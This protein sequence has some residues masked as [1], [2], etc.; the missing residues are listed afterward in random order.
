[1]HGTE[2]PFQYGR[3]DEHAHIP[4]SIA[5]YNAQ[6]EAPRSSV[7]HVQKGYAPQRDSLACGRV[8]ADLTPQSLDGPNFP[9]LVP[10]GTLAQAGPVH[11]WDDATDEDVP[12]AAQL[13][14][15]SPP[16]VLS[17]VSAQTGVPTMRHQPT[18][19]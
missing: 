12:H 18:I 14:G 3:P 7:S 16:H 13:E 9:P 6:M 11:V 5:S 2:N 19:S 8:Y 17:S 10:G 1:M 4:P 15:Q